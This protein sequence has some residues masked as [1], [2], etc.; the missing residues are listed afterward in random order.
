MRAAS[1]LL[2]QVRRAGRAWQSGTATA[3]M[4]SAQVY[5]QEYVYWPWGKVLSE[6]A[7][8]VE[9]CCVE[10][11]LVIDYMCGTGFLLNEIVSKRPEI[12]ALGCDISRP[13]MDYARRRYPGV[14]F[15]RHDALEYE[16]ARCPDFITC[17]AGLHHLPRKDQPMFVEKV[18]SELPSGGY[19][20]V[21]EEIIGEYS[22]EKQRRRA[23][24]E[25]VW[26]LMEF[27]ETTGAPEAVVQAAADMLV[28]EW[29]ERGEYK[30]SGM[31]LEAMLSRHFS[32]LSARQVWPAEPAG[33]GDWLFLCQ[34]K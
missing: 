15:V 5:E 19:F 6:A 10:P 23:L 25:M 20:L 13:Y 22:D 29:C 16:P 26:E 11:A 3:R 32:I 7:A 30:T 33:F 14:R 21:G 8:I 24:L 18:A 9:A 12:S 1:S 34:K 2:T 17:T 4:P 31:R 28:N 27:L